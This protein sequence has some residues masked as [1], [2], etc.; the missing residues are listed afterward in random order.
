MNR[1]IDYIGGGKSRQRYRDTQTGRHDIKNKLSKK[2]R[3]AKVE[4]R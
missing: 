2:V 4:N 1:Q 3:W